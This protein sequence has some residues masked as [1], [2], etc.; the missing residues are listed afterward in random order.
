MRSSV[1]E[2]IYVVYIPSPFT[3]IVSFMDDPDNEA[4]DI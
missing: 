2:V 3:N 4:S 1:N